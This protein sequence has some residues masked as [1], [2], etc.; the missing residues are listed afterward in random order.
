LRENKKILKNHNNP[1]KSAFHYIYG[2][3]YFRIFNT[4]KNTKTKINPNQSILISINLNQ[5]QSISIN[6]NQSQSI[7]INLFQ[8]QSI[9]F[10]LNQSQSIYFNPHRHF[11]RQKHP[12][13]PQNHPKTANFTEKPDSPDKK[14]G[15]PR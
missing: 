3:K 6:L 4:Q 1:K 11:V 9:H 7:S 10:N 15:S 5:S 14:C 13:T 2:K 8:S 12:K